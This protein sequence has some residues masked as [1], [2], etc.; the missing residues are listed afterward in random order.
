VA[1]CRTAL[2]VA[3]HVG[4]KTAT[5]VRMTGNLDT[6][7]DAKFETAG[8]LFQETDFVVIHFKGTDVAAHDRRPFEKRD[9]IS[10]ID[11]ALGRFLTAHPEL[12]GNL[13]I[14]VSAD[15][16]T[17]SISG[18]HIPNPVPLLLATWNAESD[19]EDDFDEEST[20]RGALGVLESGELAHLLSLTD[21]EEVRASLR[22]AG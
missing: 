5:S 21:E 10:A 3:R 22:P 4:L 11:A 12:S 7:L 9:F 13:R 19:D 20:A 17:S 6:D 2:G 18:S 14:V 16:G 1:G 15:H 8:S